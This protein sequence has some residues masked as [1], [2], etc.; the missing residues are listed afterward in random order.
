M[1]HQTCV[2][3]TGPTRRW[4]GCCH[5]GP[6]GT[7]GRVVERWNRDGQPDPSLQY[8]L[9]G[10]ALRSNDVGSPSNGCDERLA[11]IAPFDVVADA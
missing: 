11:S 7:T 6:S 8:E 3:R 5:A 4:S 1:T 10:G 9:K 2:R